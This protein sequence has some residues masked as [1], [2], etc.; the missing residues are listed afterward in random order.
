MVRTARYAAES[1]VPNLNVDHESTYCVAD[2]RVFHFDQ[3][4]VITHL[5]NDDWSQLEGRIWLVHDKRLRFDVGGGSHN[6]RDCCRIG[7]IAMIKAVKLCE[8]K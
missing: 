2:S 8:G 3:E 4:L 6:Y 1:Q 7:R 5:I